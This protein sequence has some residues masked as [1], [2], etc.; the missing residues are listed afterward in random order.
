MNI[1]VVTA[2][3]LEICESIKLFGNSRKLMTSA[4]CWQK[5]IYCPWVICALP[6]DSSSEGMTLSWMRCV[7]QY[8]LLWHMT[9]IMVYLDISINHLNSVMYSTKQALPH[10]P[11]MMSVLNLIVKLHFKIIFRRRSLCK[12]SSSLFAVVYHSHFCIG[13]QINL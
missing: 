9:C 6:Y 3:F 4:V 1:I 8:H 12:L 7:S 2:V 5:V 11:L 10:S 13:L